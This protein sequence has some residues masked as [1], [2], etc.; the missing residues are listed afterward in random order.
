[1]I[2]PA[3]LRTPSAAIAVPVTSWALA[4]HPRVLQACSPWFQFLTGLSLQP[5]EARH[6]LC[7][8]Y[9]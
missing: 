4:S 3:G 8:M 6:L 9:V 7:T 1:M 2:S 5:P